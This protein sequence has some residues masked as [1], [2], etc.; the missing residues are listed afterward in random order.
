MDR[1]VPDRS[2][3]EDTLLEVIA[4]QSDALRPS[5]RRVAELILNDPSAAVD[6]TLAAL[7]RAAGVSEPTVLR[8][9]AAIGCE[10][11]R[12][13]RVKL[14]RSLAFAR[15]TSHSAI[16]AE[17]DLPEIVEKM[18]DFNLSNLAWARSRLDR[19]AVGRAVDLISRARRLDFFGLGASAIVAQDAAQKFPLFGVPCSAPRDGHQMF[20]TASMLGEGDVAVGI[21]NTGTTRDVVQSLAIA[22]RGGAATV[23]LCG[24]AS[25]QM[26]AECDVALVIET[27]ENT[28]VY[29]PTVS[30]LSALVVV[31][32]L[33]TAAS[34]AHGPGHGD[35]V[36][37]MKEGLARY[38]TG[39]D[40]WE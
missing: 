10:G 1:D 8:F 3:L 12:D 17:D 4:R 19:A 22:R 15:T 31:D 26:L 9:A 24:D 38:R 27:L 32:I 30:R 35:R 40:P 34:L 7:A 13:L 16:S 29:T 23:G 39:D 18:F 33:S 20:M 6:M 37:A 36:A 2:G 11:I 25:G 14:A 28:D 21:S 5:D